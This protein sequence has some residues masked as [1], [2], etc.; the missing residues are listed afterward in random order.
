ML[1][2]IIS[3]TGMMGSGKT[4]IGNSLALKLDYQFIDLDQH[5]EKRTKKTINKIFQ[6]RGEEYFRKLETSYLAEIINRQ[7]NLILSTGG[8]IILAAENRKLLAE[9]TISI[10]L[11]ASLDILASR[12]INDQDRPLL[13]NKKELNQTLRSIYNQR[14]RFYQEAPY[15]IN[16]DISN[17][18][19][20]VKQIIDI[21]NE[22]SK[23]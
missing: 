15:I 13:K 18:D 11:E 10:Y 22:K 8:G 21:I 14:C 3:L 12:L 1:K 5:I 20:L 9:K 17:E 23:S 7:K 4:T 2:N 19:I 6:D 16:T